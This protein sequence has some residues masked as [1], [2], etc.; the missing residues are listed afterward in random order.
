MSEDIP[1]PESVEIT[2]ADIKAKLKTLVIP[3]IGHKQLEE[4]FRMGDLNHSQTV[5][6]EELKQLFIGKV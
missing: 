2:L 1:D 3:S 6:K 5:E 4:L